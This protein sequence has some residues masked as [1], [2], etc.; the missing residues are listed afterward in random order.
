M[1]GE[2]GRPGGAGSGAWRE[3]RATSPEG[4]GRKHRSKWTNAST[5]S[6][7]GSRCGWRR[8]SPLPPSLMATART[9]VWPLGPTEVASAAEGA[10]VAAGANR[11]GRDDPAAIRRHDLRRRRGDAERRLPHAV[12]VFRRE[13]KTDKDSDEVRT[14]LT[15]MVYFARCQASPTVRD[16]RAQCVDL[17]NALMREGNDAAEGQREYVGARK[18]HRARDLQAAQMM[19]VVSWM[20]LPGLADLMRRDR[21]TKGPKEMEEE[22]LRRDLVG[23]VEEFGTA[24]V[25]MDDYVVRWMANHPHPPAAGGPERQ[26]QHPPSTETLNRLAE[27]GFLYV[28]FRTLSDSA[29]SSQVTQTPSMWGDRCRWGTEQHRGRPVVFQ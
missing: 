18:W 24:A 10:A 21:I 6:E 19:A 29:L 7:G 22:M 5:T 16:D 20:I 23:E 14:S 15:D 26:R 1:I 17:F 28:T 8:R 13:M 11:H 2:R 3:G 12:A 27:N 4:W 25:F 9:G